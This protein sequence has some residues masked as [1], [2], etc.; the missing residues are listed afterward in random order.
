MGNTHGRLYLPRTLFVVSRYFRTELSTIVQ[1]TQVLAVC[2][3]LRCCGAFLC[4]WHSYHFVTFVPSAILTGSEGET[5]GY[6]PVGPFWVTP[7]WVRF[8]L[9]SVACTF[10]LVWS[11]H[12]NLISIIVNPCLRY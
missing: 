9:S 4:T 2:R 3:T 10:V 7:P 8:V 12:T 11:L 5:L 1:G 6:P